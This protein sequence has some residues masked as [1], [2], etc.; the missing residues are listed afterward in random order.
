MTTIV[1]ICSANYLAHAK[2]LGDSVKKHNPD[3]HF[4]IGLADRLTKDFTDSFWKPHELISA[5]EI[6]I[7]GIGEMVQKYNVVE[8]NTAVKPF[9][10][11][12]L[13]RRSNVEQ[14]IYLDPDILV[15]S[16][17]AALSEKLRSHCLIVTPHS[18]TY[19]NSAENIYYETGMLGTG[20]YNLGFL[21][22]SRS[23]VT[24]SFLKWWQHRLREFCY[25]TPG[26]GIFVD[27]LWVTLAPLYFP[28]VF[29]EK[30]PGF[31]MAYWNVFERTISQRKGRHHVNGEHE[32]VFFHFSSFD[33]EK[34]NAMT[35][36]D[37]SMTKPL[38]ERPDLSPLYTEYSR[39]LIGAGY[40]KV[41]MLKY[42]LREHLP[43]KGRT[44]K[45][46]LKA[47][48][49]RLLRSLPTRIQQGLQRVA[50][51]SINALK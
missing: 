34:P 24:F 7:E 16:S 33:P 31:N 49:C 4:V 23:E 11:E 14:V 47:G 32:L 30:H 44:L 9:F 20:I 6:G 38:A 22:T 1:T 28:G 19:D 43:A 48:Y 17:L 5:E 46:Q 25:Y 51:I 29:I 12:F 15:F 2:V 42:S 10:I 27:Q 18:C 37:K 13:Y 21:G 3:Y 50:Q 26:T 41:K 39:L 45:A 8:F 35:K 36:R 40:P